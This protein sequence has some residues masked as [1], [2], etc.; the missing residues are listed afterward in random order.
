MPILLFW[1]YITDLYLHVFQ[2]ARSFQATER[3]A[4]RRKGSVRV[5]S[6]HG[7]H[8]AKDVGGNAE[9]LEDETCDGTDLQDKCQREE[10]DDPVVVRFVYSA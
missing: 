9:D 1:A 10:D 4:T 2:Q 7:R 8:V 6:R 3:T 5:F